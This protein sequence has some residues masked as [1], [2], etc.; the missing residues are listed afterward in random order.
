MTSLR[1]T[2]GIRE[3]IRNLA[4]LELNKK[5]RRELI[6]ASTSCFAKFIGIN[7]LLQDEISIASQKGLKGDE[8][9]KWI[10]GSLSDYCHQF[11]ERVTSYDL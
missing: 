3:K 8:A 4:D 6:K 9:Y 1:K 11:N 2:I 7:Q 5:Q 10:S